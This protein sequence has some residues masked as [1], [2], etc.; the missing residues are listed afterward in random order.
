MGSGLRSAVAF[1][2][3]RRGPRQEP[4]FHVQSDCRVDHF[5]GVHFHE[6]FTCRILAEDD[7]PAQFEGIPAAKVN[8]VTEV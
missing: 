6:V 7:K 2:N 4:R 3:R 8:G 5:S 1:T